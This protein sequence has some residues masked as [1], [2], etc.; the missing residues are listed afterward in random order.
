LLIIYVSA[1]FAAIDA[2]RHA[3]HRD[4]IPWPPALTPAA[5]FLLIVSALL[6]GIFLTVGLPPVLHDP[7]NSRC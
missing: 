5:I 3:H 2:S 6:V 7:P 1:L 4:E